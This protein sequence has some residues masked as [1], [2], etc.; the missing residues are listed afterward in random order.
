MNEGLHTH[1]IHKYNI[2][3]GWTPQHI[4]CLVHGIYR[5]ISNQRLYSLIKL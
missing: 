5:A 4:V 2:L 1:R 3:D